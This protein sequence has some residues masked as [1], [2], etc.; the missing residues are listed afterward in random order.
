MIF[1]SGR[2]SARIGKAKAFTAT[3]RKVAALFYNSVRHGM[4]T[5][6]GASATKDATASGNDLHRRAKAFGFASS[7]WSRHL[8]LSFLWNRS[9]VSVRQSG[10]HR[11]HRSAAATRTEHIGSTAVKLRLP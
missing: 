10:V 5:S 4:G 1:S 8:M 11:F 6:T 2:L 7:P 3:A 9:P